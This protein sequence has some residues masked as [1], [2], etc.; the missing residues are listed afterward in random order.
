MKTPDGKIRLE[1]ARKI[2]AE[3]EALDKKEEQQRAQEQKP[4]G[5]KSGASI[6]MTG[7]VGSDA[8]AAIA[9]HARAIPGGFSG[10][11]KSRPG[12]LPGGSKSGASRFMTEMVG[13][14][15][16]AA[17][18]LRPRELPGGLSGDFEWRHNSK[19]R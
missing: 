14:D 18:H 1:R 4:Q 15:A 6:V 5:S 2:L 10:E 8:G 3:F 12:G 17:S 9:P 13:S 16:V 7:M 19:P 11:P